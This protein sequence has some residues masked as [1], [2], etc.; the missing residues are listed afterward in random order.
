MNSETRVHHTILYP[1]Y[2]QLRIRFVAR[3][4]A[5]IVPN[6]IQTRKAHA[7]THAGVVTQ[8]IP[9]GAVITAP[10]LHVTLHPGAAGTGNQ[11]WAFFRRKSLLRFERGTHHQQWHHRADIFDGNFFAKAV[12]AGFAVP[13]FVFV[14]IIPGGIDTHFQQLRGDAVLPPFHRCRIGEIKMRTFVVPEDRTL[15]AILL[16]ILNKQTLFNHFLVTRMILQQTWFDVSCQFDPCGMERLGHH[17]RLRHLV[18][19]PVKDIALVI[20]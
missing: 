10:G 8:R 14:I 7:H 5:D 19:V 6:V 16:R 9:V 13:H 17:F 3:K 2:K 18:V 1:A 4:A 12:T 11:I 15:R 20:D